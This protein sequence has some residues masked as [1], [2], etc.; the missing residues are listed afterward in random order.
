MNRTA[1]YTAVATAAAAI[2]TGIA[3][4]WASSHREAP[5]I[6]ENPKID[7]TDFYMFRSY[8]A[9]RSDFVTFIA[10]YQ[11][12]QAPYGG[13]N[14]FTM[15][16]DAI[17]EIHVDTD[18]DAVEDITY[19]FNFDN[20]LANGTG[21]EIPVNGENLS[22]A[23]RQAGAISQ[24]VNDPNQAE[25]ESYTITQIDGDRRS[26]T[27][28]LVTI[29][30][31]TVT[32]IEKPIDNIGTKTIPDYAAYANL[33]VR[34]VTFPGC[35]VTGRAFVGQRAEAFAVNLGP[36]F[37]LVNF[38]PLE[39]SIAQDRE[40]NDDLV[41]EF[42]ITSLA[43]EVP[44]ECLNVGDDNIIGGWTTASLPQAAIE[45]PTPDFETPTQ[46]GGAFVQK[47]R[48]SAPLV[49]EL[50]I[51][52]VDKDRF[53]SSEPVF[54]ADPTVGFGKYV[55]TPTLP[56]LLEILFGGA[57]VQ[58]PN[59]FPR[60]DLVAAFLTGIEG[61][62]Q[63]TDVGVVPAE[64]LRLNVSIPTTAATAQNP[65]GVLAGDNAGFPN[66]RRPGDDTVD[67]ALRAVM[68]AICHAG[69]GL[70]EPADAPSGT[71]PFTDGAPLGGGDD[72]ILLP[73]FPYLGT[74]IP[75]ATNP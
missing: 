69:L 48:L 56:E 72:P 31:S 63:P 22:I 28:N 1:K 61:V 46:Y 32:N 50:V 3:P 35:A 40:E 14:Y 73:N 29:A 2:L 51:G 34:N 67:I 12:I 70:C 5:A 49:N 13:P 47:S 75:G 4:V 45:D 17:Y 44:I 19:Q 39:G 33:F 18:G 54:D 16:P 36:I 62:N 10:N 27:R 71:L 41:G 20:N 7:G 43:L 60:N 52:L 11:P 8:Q 26:G 21:I 30:N 55:F 66:G 53:N 37:D 9:G 68:G 6:T 58:A 25:R 24:R 74:P 59:N 23:L 65:L 15:D 57:G 38:T 64:M 42:N